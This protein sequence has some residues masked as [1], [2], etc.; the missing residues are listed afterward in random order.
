MSVD[1]TAAMIN[2]ALDLR[3]AEIR[4][5]LPPDRQDAAVLEAHFMA[6]HLHAVL[7]AQRAPRCEVS[8]DGRSFRCY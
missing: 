8:S 5:T 3:L 6:D 2:Q 7:R 1:L 4:R